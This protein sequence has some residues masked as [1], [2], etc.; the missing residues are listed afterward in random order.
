MRFMEKESGEDEDKKVIYGR[1]CAKAFCR[2]SPWL[3]F[4]P[5]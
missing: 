3:Q 4:V 1:K 5:S 2:Y